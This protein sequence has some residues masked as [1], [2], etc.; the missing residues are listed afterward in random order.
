MNRLA[1]KRPASRTSAFSNELR[2]LRAENARLLALARG[3]FDVAALLDE[4]GFLQTVSPA[5]TRAIS[6][7]FASGATLWEF[8]HPDDLHFLKGA[9]AATL[10]SADEITMRFRVRNAAGEWL[11][12]DARLRDE[13]HVSGVA[14]LVFNARDV[15]NC[16]AA[17]ESL[18]EAHAELDAVIDAAPIFLFRWNRDGVYTFARGNFN[19]VLGVAP[20]DRVGH[21]VYELFAHK[22]EIARNFERALAGETFQTTV[23][24]GDNPFDALYTPAYDQNGAIVGVIG[25]TMD[26]SKIYEAQHAIEDARVRA[27]F[28]SAQAEVLDR[29]A[30]AGEFRDDDTG[31]HTRRVGDMSAQ[32]AARLGFAP[33]RV[34][35]MRRAAPLHDIGKIG[36]PDNILL[37]PGKLTSEEFDIIKTHCEIGARLLNNGKSEMVQMAQKIALSHHERF[38]GRGYPTQLASDQIPIEGRI[39]AVVDV[40]DALTS[41]RPYKA[42]WLAKDALAEIAKVR[43]HAVRSRR[44]RS[45]STNVRGRIGIIRDEKSRLPPCS[46]GA[47][48]AANESTNL[49]C[50]P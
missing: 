35:I 27:E 5:A 17:T 42:A 19:T 20:Q 23:H 29:L 48:M 32:L 21:S 8:V 38:D 12:L 44:R 1:L 49:V 47:L 34:E 16:V 36:V 45:V 7:Q 37:K 43:G 26:A 14:A 15:S 30:R 11:I 3:G 9:F 25:A 41:Q 28:E 50:K 22:P 13:R 31:Q 6:A 10:V 24:F 46:H 4:N 18:H 33:E 2:R 40:F 39:V